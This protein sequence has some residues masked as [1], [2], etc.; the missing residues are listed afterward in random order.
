MKP[1]GPG[2]LIF[3]FP[4]FIILLWQYLQKDPQ[5]PERG[6]EGDYLT[7]FY[8]GRSDPKFPRSNPFPSIDKLVPL[9]LCIL[10]HGGREYCMTPA[11]AAAK[12]TISIATW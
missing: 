4:Y 6:G 10:V 5:D 1:P 2:E 7:K 11:R 3:Q 12:E 8:Q 9:L